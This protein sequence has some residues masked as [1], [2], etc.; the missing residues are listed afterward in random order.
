MDSSNIQPV[1]VT[2]PSVWNQTVMLSGEFFRSVAL[3]RAPCLQEEALAVIHGDPVILAV[4]CVLYVEGF[5]AQANQR[6]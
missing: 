5:D 6:T 1:C 4:A 2:L 3:G